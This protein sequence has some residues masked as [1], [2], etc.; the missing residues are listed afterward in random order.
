MAFD[1]KV[2]LN[3]GEKFMKKV[4]LMFAM[5]ALTFSVFGQS[6]K[7]YFNA[8]K[9]K[10]EQGDAESQY[11]LAWLYALGRGCNENK[12]LAFSWFKKSS[13]NGYARAY[14]CLGLYYYQ[15]IGTAIDYNKAFY[16]YRKAVWEDTYYDFFETKLAREGLADC[17]RYGRGVPQNIEVAKYWYYKA[18][19]KKLYELDAYYKPPKIVFEVCNGN[20]AT[21][22]LSSYEIDS[23]KIINFIKREKHRGINVYK[24]GTKF[25]VDINNIFIYSSL[26]L[27]NHRNVIYVFTHLYGVMN[28]SMSSDKFV[29]SSSLPNKNNLATIDF[30][31][32]TTSST[33][34]Y[35]LRAGIKSDSKITNV[36]V[37]VNNGRGI[38]SVI[39]DGYDF[40]LNKNLT[41]DYGNNTITV[42]VTNGSGTTSKSFD[43]YV[44]TNNNNNYTTSGKRVALVIGNANYPTSPL[45]NPVNDATDIAAKLK[46]LGFDVTLQNNLTHSGFETVLKNFKYKASNSDIALFYYAGHGMEIDGINYLIPIDAPIDDENQL[47]YKSVNANYALDMISVATKKII[48]L[49]ACRNNPTRGIMH[50]GLGVMS[51]TNAFFAYSTS[52]GKTA[53][54]GNGRN[55]PYTSALLSALGYKNLTLPQLFQKV[56]QIV[57]SKNNS[58]IPW[59]SSSLVDDVILN[60]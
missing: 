3:I 18:E 39:S 47:K 56:S 4:I 54:D 10:A 35:N 46:I 11:D 13:E 59:T 51:A 44:S 20:N 34:S 2:L 14:H 53:P 42:S 55:S 57:T 45:R 8:S 1:E 38:S 31:S 21:T 26:D 29:I 15:G 36:S 49:D 28:S 30:K 16:W 48:I 12:Y 60:N 5:I 27:D 25:C 41:L 43:V 24:D 19:S 22:I 23:V 17:F 52:P 6:K 58:Q 7:D 37:S 40:T 32:F 33:T 50:G 9:A